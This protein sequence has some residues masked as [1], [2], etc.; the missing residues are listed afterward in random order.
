MNL[1]YFL[2]LAGSDGLQLGE[3]LLHAGSADA[4]EDAI[5]LEEFATDVEGKVFAV[6]DAANEAEVLRE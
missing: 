2:G 1:R 5:L 3:D 6:D 4:G